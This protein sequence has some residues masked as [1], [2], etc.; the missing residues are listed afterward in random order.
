MVL[1]RRLGLLSLVVALLLSRPGVG[2]ASGEAGG[3]VDETLVW[4]QVMLDAIVAGTLGNPQTLRMAATV[5]TAMFDAGNGVS[6]KYTPIFVTQAAPAGT[7]RRAAVVQAAYVTLKAFHPAQ[8]ARFDKQRASSLAEFKGDDAAKV[9]RGI[10]WGENVAKQVLAWRASD[11]F[12]NPVPPFNGAGAVI[13]QWES[14]T[15]ASMAPGNIPFTAPFV[16]TSNA[17]FQSAFPRPWA[18]LDSAAYAASFNELAMMG[19]K[20]GSLRTLDQTRIAFFFNGYATNDYVEAAIQIAKARQTPRRKNSR[21]FSLLTIAMH[22]TSVTVFRAKRDFAMNPADVTWRPILAIP[23]AELD[24]NP[25]TT[26]ISGWIPLITTPNHP[27]Y[28]GSHPGSHGSGPRVLQHFFG[29][30][31]A[32]ELHPAFNT[33][34]PG[35]PEGGVQPRHYTRISDMAQEGIDSRTYGGMHFRGA[36]NATAVVGAQ[37]ADYILANAARPLDDDDSDSD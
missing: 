13:G 30:V 1:F 28:P 8:L 11:G 29:D 34:F 26:P 37:I 6:R 20:T 15:G 14:A 12:S 3:I 7:H 36:S 18:T 17:Q 10:D 23:K 19:V 35:P 24:G 4:N 22:D 2:T 27:E 33:V 5:N 16:L 9:Q 32:F 31:N 21:I 25:N